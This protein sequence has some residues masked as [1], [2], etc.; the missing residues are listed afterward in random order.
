[1]M[2]YLPRYRLAPRGERAVK[3]NPA[4][5]RS[6]RGGETKVARREGVAPTDPDRFFHHLAVEQSRKI[7][8]LTTLFFFTLTPLLALLAPHFSTGGMLLWQVSALCG[9]LTLL[10][11][12]IV[13][14]VH[15]KRISHHVE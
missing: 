9:F 13:T 7:L 11:L 6:Q 8:F 2:E 5:S 15:Y 4:R 10:F 3:K 1:M 14:L 12:F